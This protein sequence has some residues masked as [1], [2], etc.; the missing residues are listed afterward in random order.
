MELTLKS[1]GGRPVMTPLGSDVRRGLTGAI[2]IVGE[3]LRD[4]FINLGR[5]A[6]T[7][8]RGA[9]LDMLHIDPVLIDAGAPC[10]DS[11]RARVDRRYPRA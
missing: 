5:K 11:I 8:M 10:H 1:I 7:E 6:I 4:D 9:D 2:A 3:S